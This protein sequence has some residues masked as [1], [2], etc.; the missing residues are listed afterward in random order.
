VV[1]KERL[2]VSENYHQDGVNP[3]V[4]SI[5][6]HDII[7]IQ[8]GTAL[9]VGWFSVHFREAQRLVSVTFLFKAT[10]GKGHFLAAVREYR[11]AV[12]RVPKDLPPQLG[13]NHW[14]DV[15]ERHQGVQATHLKSLLI[16]GEQP[17]QLLRSTAKWGMDH[18]WLRRIPV[19]LSTN[20]ICVAT[21][22]G[23]LHVADEPTHR[24]GVLNFAMNTTS[25]PPDAIKSATLLERNAY[26][27]TLCSLQLELCRAPVT[28]VHTIPYCEESRD[29]AHELALHLNEIRLPE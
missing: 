29:A 23:F 1:T 20:G 25:I 5:P 21:N 9:L 24:P 17:I 6:F 26:G 15:L 27:C 4:H 8:V 16:E 12:R 19:C 14:A 18:R 11:K 22:S 10:T 2:L 28:L 7:T 13:A 3:S